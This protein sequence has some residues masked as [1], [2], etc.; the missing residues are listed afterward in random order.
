MLGAIEMRAE[1]HT[2]V[3]DFAKSREA[4]NLVAAGIGQDRAGPR[5]ELM[6]AAKA[7]NQLMART[8]IKMIRVG[9][10]NFSAKLFERFLRQRFYRSLRANG[11]EERCL[12]HAVRRGQAA[13]PRA[14]RVVLQNFKGKRHALSVSGEDE[15]D[16][17]ANHDV[18]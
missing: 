14:L 13:T 12:H 8:Q 6:Q 18:S 3:G 9:E 1:A 17:D 5:H 11:Q 16:S 4:E 2:F 7:P 15:S 10:D